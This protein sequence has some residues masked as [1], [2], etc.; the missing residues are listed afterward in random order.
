MR[1]ASERGGS[2]G[3]MDDLVYR[4]IAGNEARNRRG[5]R[6]VLYS[7]EE[8]RILYGSVEGIKIGYGE[9]GREN[10]E[11]LNIDT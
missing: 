11:G 7:V 3:G 1:M 8:P 2:L 9:G 6:W 4:E 10:R 5:P